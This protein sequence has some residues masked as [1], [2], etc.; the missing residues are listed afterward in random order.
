MLQR[1]RKTANNLTALPSNADRSR[2]VPPPHLTDSERR[3]FAEIVAACP[4]RQFVAT[5]ALL[6]AS[7]VQATML[8]RDAARTAAGDPRALATWEKAT[9]AQTMLARALRLTPQ[10]RVDPKV[11]GR[12]RSEPS[13]SA[14]DVMR[15]EREANDAAE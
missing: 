1:G 15:M 2:L 13:L 12:N 9:R 7:F 14:Y 6:L 10:A 3:L 5:D 4:V 11:I 8:A